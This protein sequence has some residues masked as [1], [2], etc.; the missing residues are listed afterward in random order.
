MKLRIVCLL[1]VLL[2]SAS[3]TACSGSIDNL[4]PNS[5]NDDGSQISDTA[6]PT[7]SASPSSSENTETETPVAPD[8]ALEAYEAVLQNGAEFYSIDNKKELFLNDFLTNKELFGSV[9][10]AARFTVLDMD[11]DSV[12]EVVVELT[13]DNNPEFYEVLHYM[14]GAVYGYNIVYRGLEELKTDGTFYYSNGATDYGYG[15]LKF[16]SDAYE[17]DILGYT[18]SSQNNDGVTTI[19]YFI[20]NEPVNEE[21]FHAFTEEQNGKEDVVWHEFSQA[22][23]EAELSV[24]P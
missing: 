3:I 5:S 11:G 4:S 22:N 13:V 19:S 20:D 6:V 8:S 1:L 14:D 7:I 18:E 12:P 9:F 10:N 17:N 15:K 16:Q 2:L 23:I 24:S 21:V